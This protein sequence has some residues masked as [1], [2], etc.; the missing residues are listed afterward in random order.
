MVIADQ[1]SPPDINLLTLRSLPSLFTRM[2]HENAV[3]WKVVGRRFHHDAGTL[4]NSVIKTA[5]CA[6]H[7]SDLDFSKKPMCCHSAHA[8][9]WPGTMTS[10]PALS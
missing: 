2:R 3:L 7:K 10:A 4:I 9:F 8:T 1:L 5:L 6:P